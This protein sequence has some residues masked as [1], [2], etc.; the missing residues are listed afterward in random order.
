[1]GNGEWDEPVEEANA[2]AE[3]WQEQINP[4][5]Q[6]WVRAHGLDIPS[7]GADI[8]SAAALGY[9]NFWGWCEE[10][11][12]GTLSAETAKGAP[13]V[14]PIPT[15]AT[16]PP[17]GADLWTLML[18]AMGQRID[19]PVALA[20]LEAIG[21][22]PLKPATPN[23]D[24]T[25]TTTKSL[26]I[27][28]SAGCNPKNRAYWPPRK[29]GRAWVNYVIGIKLE[30]SYAGP[31]PQGFEWAMT[32]EALDAVGDG[33]LPLARKMMQ[34]AQAVL[35]VGG[36]AINIESAGLAQSPAEWAQLRSL[37]TNFFAYISA[38]V[39]YVTSDT[40]HYTCRMH[41][42]GHAD[43]ICP[44]SLSTAEG[45]ELMTQFL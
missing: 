29:E 8:V 34:A 39:A 22:K 37:E 45:N 20:L 43:A 25:S 36:L 1:L 2:Y 10:A 9:P 41:N 31:L 33:S 32:E 14:E 35:D 24:V 19:S 11:V 7:T 13:P 5:F 40:H 23:S 28:V 17:E 16:E 12:E 42:L 30:P 3:D 21:A 6:D 15:T 27:E 26:G 44:A 38:Y 18:A 4:A